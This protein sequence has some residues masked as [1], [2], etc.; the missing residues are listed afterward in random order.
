MTKLYTIV[1]KR[2]VL[3]DIKRIPGVILKNIQKRIDLLPGNPFPS[4]AEPVEGYKHYYR[5]RVGDY[6]VVYE[7]AAQIGIITII[8]IGH[9]RDVYRKL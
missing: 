6:R 1:F 3:K 8:K 4:G 9:R 5:I 2:S 7:V